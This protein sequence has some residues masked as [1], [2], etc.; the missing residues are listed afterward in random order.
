M[1]G[2]GGFRRSR[3]PQYGV[4]LYLLALLKPGA[5]NT[6]TIFRP[7]TGALGQAMRASV[8]VIGG[9][10]ARCPTPFAAMAVAPCP[11]PATRA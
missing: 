4:T 11:L 9:L 7:N 3:R 1:H 10:Q 5:R 8:W 2:G 6:F